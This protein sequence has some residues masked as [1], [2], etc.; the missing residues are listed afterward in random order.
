[1]YRKFDSTHVTCSSLKTN[2][3]KIK[4]WCKIAV[5]F[6]CLVLLAS[7][8]TSSGPA[9]VQTTPD[10]G[11]A[12]IYVYKVGRFLGSGNSWHLS[13]NG[14]RIAILIN[15]GYIPYVADTGNV[16]FSVK[17]RPGIGTLLTAAFMPEAELITIN[18]EPNKT[19]FVRFRLG[20]SMELVSSEQGLQEN[21]NS[22]QFPLNE[23]DFQ[24]NQNSKTSTNSE[25]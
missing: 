7:C 2:R 10:T 20:P 21:Q 8:A 17:L 13:A 3:F 22:K 6:A 1:M 16:T 4:G 18:A 5:S 15:E 23:R 12:I 25:N 24:E 14:Q 9:F 11:K 19:Y